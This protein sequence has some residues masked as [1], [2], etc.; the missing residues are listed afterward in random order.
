MTARYFVDTNVFVYARDSSEPAKQAAASQ[1]LS[2]LWQSRAG[3]VSYPVLQEYYLIVTRRLS[4]GL[5]SAIAR[6]DV[7]DLL[8]WDPVTTNSAVLEGAWRVQDRFSVSW[9]DALI[10]A[11]ARIG[12]CDYLLTE[13]LQ[14]GQE[15]DGVTVLNPFDVAVPD[16]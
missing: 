11:A 12:Q 1:W 13:D 16:L 10:V 7:R 9:W 15:L 6:D 3:R 2:S 5:P 4:P 14:H 8:V